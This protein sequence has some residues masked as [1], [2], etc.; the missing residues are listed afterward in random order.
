VTG[1]RPVRPK[2]RDLAAATPAHRDR[3]V[4]LLRAASICVVVLGHWTIGAV[5]AGDDGVG[6][7]N[8]LSVEPWTHPFTWV[9]QV[10]PVFFLVGG[11]ANAASLAAGRRRGGTTAGWVRQRA[12]RLLRPTAAFLAVLVGAR[13]VAVLLGADE[14]LVRTATWAA[15]AP[16]W[17]LVVYLAVV[18]LAPLSAAAH[19]R[20]GL[21]AVGVLVL[22]VAVGDVLRLA[23]GDV[24]P[25]TANYL[26]AWLAV[27]QAGVAWHDQA[28]P[29][30]RGAAWSLI[31]AGLGTA[32]LLTGPGPYGV[33]MVGAATAPDL[34]NT[35]PPT[36]A[37]LALATAQVGAVILLRGPATAWLARPRTWTAVVV[38]NSV[39]LTVFLW[40][41]AALVI[42][43]L[44]LIG[45]G[46]FPQPPVGSG[47]WFALRIPWL[48]APTAVL[49]GLVAL[50]GR[51]EAPV[52][53][54]PG[55]RP[56]SPAV[57]LGVVAVVVGMASLGVSDTRGVAPPLAGIPLVELALIAGGLAV[58]SRAGRRGGSADE[59]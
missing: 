20:W 57:A 19:R 36:L 30:T 34:T 49:V 39:I 26:L 18:A 44:V 13:L 51:W 43:A 46:V 45:T 47:E 4:D 12:L 16:L 23:A 31:G 41:M 40:H 7:A 5:T 54:D 29:R 27:H 21:K 37:L 3:Y 55:E 2:A 56:S 10:M 15:A 17:F 8:L 14:E 48:L 58:L 50:M 42:A 24:G 9:F 32:L 53:A 52:R 38:L 59:V 22:A 28:L 35:A 1:Q 6:G 11:Y 25:A 33:A